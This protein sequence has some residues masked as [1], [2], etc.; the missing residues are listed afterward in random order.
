MWEQG[1]VLKDRIDITGVGRGHRDIG[2]GEFDGTGIG[3][4][5]AGDHS[6]DGR[7]TR[8]RRAK[9]T[10]EFTMEDIKV[11]GIYGYDVAKPPSEPP[12]RNCHRIDHRYLSTQTGPLG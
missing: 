11:D 12:Q 7:L 3:P 4:F 9:E 5:K 10:E 6:Q 8:S 2:T 1:V